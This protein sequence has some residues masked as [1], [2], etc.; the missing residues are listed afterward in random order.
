M[1][2]NKFLALCGLGSRRK[3]E[4]MV[5]DGRI[6]VD[7]HVVDALSFDVPENAQVLCDG[8]PVGKKEYEYL[9]LFKPKG[10]VSTKSDDKGRKTVMDLL[11]ANKK[12]LNPVGRLDYDT[13]GLLLFTN[14]GEF[15]N[16]LAH[17]S[18]EV[19]KTYD[20]KIEGSVLESELAVLRAGV[21]IDGKRTAPCKAR[22]VKT[23]KGKTTIEMV[24]HEGR[25]R[26]IRKMMEAIGKNIILLKRVKYGPIALGGLSRGKT[27]NLRKQEILALEACA[28]GGQY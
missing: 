5:L 6:S 25:N 15:A 3:C 9:M 11:P 23:E 14:D 16:M 1:R 10:F 27:R 20:V 22:V 8:E 17:P 18:S 13:E 26:E 2:I 7:G 4:Q 19:E 24:I 21:V 12:H 28:A